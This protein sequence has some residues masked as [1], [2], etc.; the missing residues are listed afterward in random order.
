MARP[1]SGTRALQIFDAAARHLSFTRAAQEVGLTASAVSHQVKELEDQ[2]EVTLFRRTSRTV[3]LTAAGSAFHA[4]VAEA[5]DI[6]IKAR[7]RARRADQGRSDLTVTMEPIFASKWMLPR[8]HALRQ[9]SPELDLRLDISMTVRDFARDHVDAAIRFGV[10]HFPGLL[11]ERLFESVIIPVCSPAL[12][13]SG[14]PLREPRDLLRHTL[15]DLEWTIADM[16]WPN[17]HAWMKAAGVEAP[18][19]LHTVSFNDSSH[20]IQAAM[21]GSVVALADLAM[22]ESDLSARRL[23]RPFEISMRLPSGFGYHL[24]YPEEAMLET[25]FQTLR[26]WILNEAKLSV[27][28]EVMQSFA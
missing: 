1:I 4:G 13:E 15:V 6:L 11:H 9:T 27:G 25:R 2:L 21:D 26:T 14:I 7:V 22:V 24:I 17:W 16:P 8:L 20:A 5:L 10:G 18:E 23:V 19:G 12:L 3:E 28:I